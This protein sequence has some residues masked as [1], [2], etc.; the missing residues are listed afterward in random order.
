MEKKKLYKSVT[1]SR[2]INNIRT[3]KPINKKSINFA[4]YVECAK[5]SSEK[6]TNVFMW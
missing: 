2:G 5:Q 6:I 4:I 1:Y 3:K